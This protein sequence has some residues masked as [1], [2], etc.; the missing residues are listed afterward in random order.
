MQSR[1]SLF[2]VPGGDTIQMLKTKEYLQKLGVN[3]EISTELEPVLKG[4]DLIHLFNLIRPQDIYLAARNAK[5]QGKKVVL[6]PI[7]VVYTEYERKGREGFSKY[8]FRL[9]TSSK[10]E[11]LKIFAR[12]VKNKEFHRATCKLILFGYLKL[13]YRILELADIMLPN[14]QSEMDRISSD[15]GLK[16][17]PYVLVPNS[18]DKNIFREDVTIDKA[19]EGIKDCILC[20]SRIEGRKNQLNLIKA[21]KNLPYELVLIGKAAPNHKK[22]YEKIKKVKSKNVHILGDVNHRLLPQ[23]YAIA[24]V[25]ILPSWFETTGLSS[26][27]AGI[28]NCNLVV[29]AKG[30]TREYFGDYVYYCDPE[31]IESI[32]EAIIRAWES[33]INPRLKEHIFNNYIWEKTAEKTLEAYHR[34]IL[35]GQK[36]NN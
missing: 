1:V 10:I 4:Y 19:L 9:L 7:Y 20:V 34:V 24:R 25:H 29:T 17:F 23:Y 30:D 11:Y 26:L 3:V 18:V 15:F 33:P 32:Q 8:L 16:S 28:M 6:S 22:Y 5:R 13:Q 27:E 14:S 36:G 12:A 21:M 35:T 31:S 2:N